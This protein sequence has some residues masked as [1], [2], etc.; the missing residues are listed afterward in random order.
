MLLEK[1]LQNI[2]PHSHIQLFEKSQRIPRVFI[3]ASSLG[4][5][6]I[7]LNILFTLHKYNVYTIKHF[8]HVS[9]YSFSTHLYIR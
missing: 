4:E 5:Y 3:K 1:I 2:M 9:N 8:V 7:N 6:G